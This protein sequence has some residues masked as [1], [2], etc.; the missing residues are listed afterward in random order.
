VVATVI[1][2]SARAEKNS[3]QDATS[4][5]NKEKWGKQGFMLNDYVSGNVSA[6]HLLE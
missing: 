6:W 3:S 2:T 1:N 4:I 5:D